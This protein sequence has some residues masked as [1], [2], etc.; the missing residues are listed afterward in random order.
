MLNLIIP[1]TSLR[2]IFSPMPP[3]TRYA[4]TYTFPNLP[5]K[6]FSKGYY[7]PSHQY[8]QKSQPQ[9]Q[10]ISN[11]FMRNPSRRKRPCLS[12]LGYKAMLMP[13]TRT[14]P[15][16]IRSHSD[17]HYIICQPSVTPFVLNLYL[18]F[19]SKTTLILNKKVPFLFNTTIKLNK[20]GSFSGFYAHSPN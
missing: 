2:A 16:N 19:L 5:Y 13:S 3:F 17:F 11:V 9:K 15:F 1:Y 6:P 7:I 18:Y 20:I 4:V 12:F 10:S 14:R 8:R